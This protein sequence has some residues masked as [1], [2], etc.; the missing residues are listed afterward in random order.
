M[1]VTITLSD[2]LA[3]R[4]QMQAQSQR[5]S[6]EQW[7]LT[8]LG[9]AAELQQELQTW[10]ALNQRRFALIR[11]QYTSG[12]NELEERELAELQTAAAKALEPWDREMIEKLEPYETLA[13]QLSHSND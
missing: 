4:L 13:T 8:I 1:P 6:L 2:D 12:L 3:A 10:A 9:H 7:A 11:K 5:L